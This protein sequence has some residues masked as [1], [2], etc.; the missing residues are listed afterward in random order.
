LV[1]FPPFWSALTIVADLFVESLGDAEGA[2][3]AAS[4]PVAPP[5]PVPAPPARPPVHEVP[6][7]EGLVL[8]T[9]RAEPVAGPAPPFPVVFPPSPPRRSRAGRAATARLPAAAAPLAPSVPV[10]PGPVTPSMR[11]VR[12]AVAPFGPPVPPFPAL[13]RSLSL[14]LLDLLARASSA[15]LLRASCAWRAASALTFLLA[16]FSAA[17]CNKLYHL[18]HC[19]GTGML[20]LAPPVM[21]V[22][23]LYR[24]PD[25]DYAVLAQLNHCCSVASYA[26]DTGELL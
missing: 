23:R 8:R 11:S 9:R 20:V 22:G 14:R 10:S 7:P 13:L 4:P 24:Q 17:S 16:S 6:D 15:F 25:C 12:A 21:Y 3:R 19:Y 18:V 2:R 5:L 26:A 1:D